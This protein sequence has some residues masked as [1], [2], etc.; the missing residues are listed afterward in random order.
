M[1]P[2]IVEPAFVFNRRTDHESPLDRASP[3]SVVC[4]IMQGRGHMVGL[5]AKWPWLT[6]HRALTRVAVSYVAEAKLS[7]FD[8]PLWNCD[9]RKKRLM[10]D[11]DVPNAD[12]DG[13]LGYVL[14]ENAWSYSIVTFHY[15]YKTLNRYHNLWMLFLPTW[16]EKCDHKCLC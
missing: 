3:I 8:E 10:C 2:D 15:S 7:P 1:Y 5:G 6:V 12:R 13:H 9:L 4:V 11:F 16:F 14:L